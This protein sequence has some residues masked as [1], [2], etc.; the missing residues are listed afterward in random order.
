M[1][2]ERFKK[3]EEIYHAVL[4][5]SLEKQP[6]FLEKEC[7]G[8]VE[9]K[10][11]VETLLFFEN[12]PITLIN[13][14]PEDLAAEFLA[15]KESSV[16]FL[17]KEIGHYKIIKFIGKGGMGEVYLAE[18]KTLD[19]KIAIKFIDEKFVNEKSSLNRF[20]SEARSASAFNH[21]N[22]I[23]VY[24]IGEFE[25]RPFIVTEFIDGIT[26]KEY[27]SEKKPDLIEILDI[28]IQVASALSAANKAGIIHRDIKPENVM[29]RPD[30]LVKVLDFGIAKMS[31]QLEDFDTEAEKIFKADTKPGAI[32][33]TTNYMSPEQVRGKTITAQTDIFSFGVVLY[34][35]L[36]GKLPF[37]G[38]TPSDVMAA[39]LTKEPQPLDE[40]DREIPDRLKQV[41]EKTLQK[42]IGKRYQQAGELHNDL[43]RVKK[44]L[45]VNQEI[46]RT[47]QTGETDRGGTKT[48]RTS[49]GHN[50]EQISTVEDT[51]NVSRALG[52]NLKTVLG[53]ALGILLITVVGYGFWYYSSTNAGQ[54]ESIAVMPFTDKIGNAENEY[55]SEGL[56][57]SLINSFSQIPN[58]SVKAR[59]SVFHYKGKEIEPQKIGDELL[60]QAVL[61]GRII[62]N[63]KQLILN[64][65]LVDTRTGNQIWGKQYKGDSSDLVSLQNE[66]VRNVSDKL[67]SQLSSSE[68][69]KIAKKHTDN[70]EAYHHYLKGRYFWNKRT[71]A[72]FKKA[73]E[74]FRAAVDKDPNYA[75]AY[76]GLADS[77]VLLENF[78]GTP[79]SETLP[80]AKAYAK[81]ALAI[82]DLLPEAHASMALVFHRLWQWNEAEKE[83]KRA[84]ELN[85]NYASTHHWYSVYLRETGRF[86]ESLAEAKQAQE[87]DPLSGIIL[88]NLGVS[89]LAADDADSTVEVMKKAVELNP[90]FPWGHAILGLA[91]LK[92]KNYAEGVSATRRGAELAKDSSNAISVYGY[93]CAVAGRRG[94]AQAIIKKLEEKYSQQKGM[95]Q[96]IARVY[97]GLGER[98]KV[99]EWLE[100]DVQNRSSFL[101][102]IRWF[103]SFESVRDDPRYK[104]LLKRMNLPE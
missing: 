17:N 3:I 62:Q 45:E 73:I 26:L 93:A 44:K 98:D 58:I 74:E 54:I 11:E 72:N 64:L 59:S 94:E 27:L 61:L 10:A 85:P 67:R 83:F 88:G 33:G 52:S 25:K 21:P 75:L 69:K 29:V 2:S 34:K 14:S 97:A 99:F 38:E 37:E 20:F 76:C 18:D 1:N 86:E 30:G 55:L 42:N 46:E 48:K 80:I 56:T 103:S 39:L 49:V 82:D 41:V 95:G 71:G 79:A 8:D 92:Q 100:K 77:Y 101:P 47:L 23:T 36:T 13:S 4:Q 53:F 78:V 22:I 35:M 19:R 15:E 87:L 102:Y 66:I 16:D 70:A 91:Y 28:A 6:A 68:K 32:I 31:E 43:R 96:N 5:V 60:V 84:I 51:Q 104:D 65:E 40:F 63:D 7:G 90:K 24:E 50:T 57:E 9:L 12:N 81:R 89:Y